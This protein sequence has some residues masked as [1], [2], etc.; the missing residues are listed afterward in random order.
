M[1]IQL[2]SKT[3]LS[4][5]DTYL[6]SI[7]EV[8]EL[9][10][11]NAP[12]KKRV[13][14]KE[15]DKVKPQ[16]VVASNEVFKEQ[17]NSLKRE[18]SR[19]IRDIANEFTTSTI[20]WE[21][22]LSCQYD[23]ASFGQVY[24]PGI[25]RLG[26]SY[27]H[28]RCI[29][30]MER[31]FLHGGMF[32]LAMP[33]GQGK[34]AWCR[35]AMLWGTLYGHRK[36]PFFIGS[37]AEKAKQTLEAIKTLLYGSKELKED[38]PEILYPIAR[39]D[40]RYHLA[41]GQIF[42]GEP[43]YIVWGADSLRYPC[44]TLNEQLAQP[45]LEHCPESVYQT[46][47]GYY[48]SSAGISISTSGIDGSIRGEA[49]THPVTLEQPRPDVI[50]L[51]DIQ[52]DQKADSPESCN[53]LVRL[54]DGAVSGLAG[55]DSSISVIMPCTVT[56]VGDVSDTFLDQEKKPD[57][58]GERC[59]LVISWP[60]GITDYEIDLSSEAGKHWW[61]YRNLR[62]ESLRVYGDISLATNYYSLHRSVMDSKFVCSWE[63]RIGDARKIISC[64]Q[65]AM[66]LRFHSPDTFPAEYQNNP[67][68]LNDYSY[69]IPPKSEVCMRLASTPQYTTSIDTHTIVSFIDI[70]N[71]VLFYLTL[72][73]SLDYTATV[74]DYGTFPSLPVRMFSKHQTE[75]WK[76]LSRE[77]F[78]S[79]PQ[80]RHLA[81]IAPDGK[82]KAPLEPK[83]FYAFSRLVPEL[84]LREYK[85]HGD[86]L[87]RINKVSK[88]GIDCKW[89]EANNSIKKY[90]QHLNR[91][92]VII[93]GGQGISAAH[94][95]FEEYTY[96]KG[97]LFETQLHKG[98]KECN[99]IWKPNQD[100]M[101]QL[102]MDTSRLKS[103]VMARLS[104]PIGLPGA[105]SLYSES[106]EHHELLGLHLCESEHPE[107]REHRGR[108]K[109]QWV[110]NQGKPDNDYLDC[111]YGCYA[112]A[113]MQGCRLQIAQGETPVVRQA[114]ATRRKLSDIWQ[115]KQ[116]R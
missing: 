53:K 58:Q 40:N 28:K 89:G 57:Y 105:L 97:W 46:S 88:I 2:T 91:R 107:P 13:A 10:K 76:L 44:I 78:Q 9:E 79:H 85:I 84:L 98:L 96:T 54:I 52:K 25:I 35:V 86:N 43:T 30:K 42:R 106:P 101:Y 5:K 8:R 22:R 36:F 62:S 24:L 66:E 7:E 112:L 17:M 60:E 63:E 20:N 67:K 34:T 56:K 100:G 64:Q 33:R 18:K 55:P 31:V 114:Q 65:N 82:V 83:L 109:E 16:P 39:L 23:L 116:N 94:K 72:A 12:K 68:K 75:G 47:K 73:C 80:H 69:K 70:Q 93:A 111:L 37:T 21:R 99:W 115:E 27:D 26:L 71:E 49:E 92:D 104:T 1:S 113:S 95:Q 59:K 3:G 51:D 45:Y 90:V 50:L 103:F 15:K 29:E 14:K 4:P 108:I 19:S 38:F 77:Y 110:E 102:V 61:E 48:I 11:V 87:N 81:E 41:K 74:I 32:A 6:L